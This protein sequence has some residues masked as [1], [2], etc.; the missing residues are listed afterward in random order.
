MSANI[1]SIT[2]NLGLSHAPSVTIAPQTEVASKRFLAPLFPW[3]NDDSVNEILIN[4]PGEVFIEKAGQGFER[5]DVPMLTKKHLKQLF[6]LIANENNKVLDERSPMLNGEIYDGSRVTLVQPPISKYLTLS[7]RKKIKKVL[8]LDDYRDSDFYSQTKP[9]LM[10]EMDDYLSEED[11][12]LLQI[13]KTRNWD[14]FVKS[15]IQNHKN[16]I[17]CGGTSTGKT[18]YL[19]ACLNHIPKHERI[20]TLEDTKEIDISHPNQVRLLSNAR[21]GIQMRDLI[22]ASLR[23]RPDRIIMGEIRSAEIMD[24]ISACSTGHDGSIATLHASNPW[25]AFRRMIQLY[26]QNNV[27]SMKDTEIREEIESVVD[28]VVQITKQSGG[29]FASYV[30]FKEATTERL[31]KC[32]D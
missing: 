12:A 27:P 9:F 24:F 22:H 17:I 18:T 31:E 8:T 30:W 6:R 21:L 28:V 29:R 1:K 13:Y 25:A 4:Q 26:K 2:Q 19:N 11:W 15:A 20:L 7:I 32:T 16:I 14:K 10:E 23:L 3:L 5:F